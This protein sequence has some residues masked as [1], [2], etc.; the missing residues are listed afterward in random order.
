MLRY[1]TGYSARRTKAKNLGV[2]LVDLGNDKILSM[3]GAN[4][5]NHKMRALGFDVFEPDI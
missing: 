1:N 3:F 5:L 2:N 4:K